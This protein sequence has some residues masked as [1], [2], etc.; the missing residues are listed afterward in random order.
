[1]TRT[2]MRVLT[3]AIFAILISP[4]ARAAESPADTGRT[5]R[6]SLVSTKATS[7]S[8]NAATAA[9]AARAIQAAHCQPG[10]ALDLAYA[11][12]NPAPVIAEFCD[13]SRQIFLYDPPPAYAQVGITSELVC[14]LAGPRRT[15]R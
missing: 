7:E 12:M 3:L 9:A 4:L 11:A 2:C 14:S 10:D 5:C 8:L 1:M 6:V 13:L 15:N